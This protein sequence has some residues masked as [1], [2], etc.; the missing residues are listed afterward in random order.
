MMD[1]FT[2]ESIRLAL[3]KMF[4][5]GSYFS[6]CTIEACLASAGIDPPHE[7]LAPLR[8]LHCVHFSEMSEAMRRQTV[9]RVLALFRHA[10]FDLED[11]QKPL[12]EDATENESPG[13]LRRL[14]H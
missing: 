4:R 3:A 7:E 2:A 8:P 13:W 1:D 9:E 12:L 6:I 10:P 5:P 14:T 11:L